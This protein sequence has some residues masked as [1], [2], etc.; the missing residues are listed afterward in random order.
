MKC[1]FLCSAHLFKRVARARSSPVYVP[2][3]G[4]L[5]SGCCGLPG[6]HRS[7]SPQARIPTLPVCPG[8]TGLHQC[9]LFAGLCSKPSLR[10]CRQHVTESLS[11]SEIALVIPLFANRRIVAIRPGI[12]IGR[13]WQSCT[14]HQEVSGQDNRKHLGKTVFDS[15]RAR[16]AKMRSCEMVSVTPKRL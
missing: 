1:P 7:D 5:A 3:N 9:T 12:I 6:S 2:P 14:K 16:C 4:F 10:R 13:S 8:D 11:A 15:P